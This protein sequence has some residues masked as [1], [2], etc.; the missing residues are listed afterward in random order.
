ML[1]ALPTRAYT[2]VCL[3]GLLLCVLFAVTV[4]GGIVLAALGLG[5][6]W[7]PAT[8]LS[9]IM[10]NGTT[11]WVETPESCWRGNRTAPPAEGSECDPDRELPL[12]QGAGYYG[13]A[14]VLAVGASTLSFRR[15]DVP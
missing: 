14:L 1:K 7:Q 3:V 2:A 9:A 12:W 13:T 8:N 15:R 10:R 4:A 5:D 6:R 11:Y